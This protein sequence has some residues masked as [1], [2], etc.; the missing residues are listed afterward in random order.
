MKI[1]LIRHGLTQGNLEGRYIGCNTDESLCEQ[2]RNQLQS[3]HMPLVSRVFVSPMKRCI[4][5]AAIL[6]PGLKQQIVP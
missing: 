6:Y 1:Y 3:L 4:E 5:S 2:G